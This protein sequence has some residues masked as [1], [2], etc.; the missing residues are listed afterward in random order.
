M[1]LLIVVGS[2]ITAAAATV[3]ALR[4]DDRRA[5]ERDGRPSS[6]ARSTTAPR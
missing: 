6:P 2:I 5:A 3:G 1:E 4:A